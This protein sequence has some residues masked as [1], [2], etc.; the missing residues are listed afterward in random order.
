MENG[1]FDGINV[2]TVAMNLYES[3]SRIA[4]LA[5]NGVHPFDSPE[6]GIYGNP[7]IITDEPVLARR[8][9]F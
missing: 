1:P 8:D 3:M 6:N 7:D 2:A 9:S 4:P 5:G